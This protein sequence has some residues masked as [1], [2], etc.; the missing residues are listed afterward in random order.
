MNYVKQ[1]NCHHWKAR[2]LFSSGAI[3]IKAESRRTLTID[4]V[5]LQITSAFSVTSVI[6]H[7]KHMTGMRNTI[8]RSDGYGN[9]VLDEVVFELTQRKP[10]AEL[11]SVIPK[12]DYLK[13]RNKK[14]P[15][16]RLYSM[17]I[18]PGNELQVRTNIH[19]SI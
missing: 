1:I 3:C 18:R 16:E 14:K 15:R 7:T 13:A 11:Y 6:I 12:G 10:R 2:K 17:D 9:E 8:K 19:I 4:D 5:I